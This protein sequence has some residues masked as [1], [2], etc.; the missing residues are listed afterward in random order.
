MEKVIGNNNDKK[1]YMIVPRTGISLQDMNIRPMSTQELDTLLTSS[2]IEIIDR[3]ERSNKTLQLLGMPSGEGIATDVLVVRMS[4]QEAEQFQK[5]PQVII[6]ENQT[7]RHLSSMDLEYLKIFSTSANFTTKIFKLLIN[8]KD[9]NAPLKGVNVYITGDGLKPAVGV[10]N[11]EGI[12]ELHVQMVAPNSP[13]QL[14]I[15]PPH[16]Y[17]SFIKNNPELEEGITNTIYLT[18][19][20]E[21][22]GSDIKH[23]SLGWGQNLMGLS[24]MPP[25]IDGKQVKIAIIDSGCDNSHP[26]LRHILKGADFSSRNADSSSWSNDPYNHG[27]HCAG[28]I[29]AKSSEHSMFRGFAPEAEVHILKIFPGD[30]EVGLSAL[31]HALEYCIVNDIDIINM[32]IGVEGYD[33]IIEQTIT[34]A[35]DDGITCVVA[36]GNSFKENKTVLYP[37]SSAQVLTVSAIGDLQSVESNSLDSLTVTD[38]L[39]GNLFSPIFTCLGPEVDVCAPGVS[40]IS[41]APGSVFKLDSGTSMAAPHVTGMAALLLAH[42]PIFQSEFKTRNRQRVEALMAL[43]HQQCKPLNLDSDRCGTGVPILGSVVTIPDH[44]P[45]PNPVS[46]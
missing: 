30:R 31:Q 41:T 25:D 27:T 24:K 43:L 39:D 45:I 6:S 21:N 8:G 37:G 35:V 12:V 38:K 5:N 40:I 19:I 33:P 3:I 28:V 44:L 26:S 18:S 2:N 10:T 36:A 23:F 1:S 34:A 29:A 14:K 42:H 7:L 4:P 15:M 16:S 9:S 11:E 22:N 46:V 13:F 17:W 20:F 32:S